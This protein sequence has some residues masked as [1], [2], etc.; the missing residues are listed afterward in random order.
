VPFFTLKLNFHIIKFFFQKKS[1]G[2]G[3]C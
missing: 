1:L 3:C 2:L